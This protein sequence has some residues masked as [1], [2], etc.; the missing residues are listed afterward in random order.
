M[1]LHV[2]LRENS[3]VS[4]TDNMYS[5]F[6]DWLDEL[7][8]QQI[9]VDL[10][11]IL[12]YVCAVGL[13][14]TEVL[15]VL[16][17]RLE[18]YVRCDILGRT[19]LFYSMAYGQVDGFQSRI[20]C[21]LDQS[22]RMQM[23]AQMRQ[24][25]DINDA[26]MFHAAMLNREPHN[27]SYCLD[28]A[29]DEEHLTK[30]GD[31]VYNTLDKSDNLL[32]SSG[33]FKNEPAWKS[34]RL[35]LAR[36]RMASRFARMPVYVNMQATN[37]FEP[38]DGRKYNGISGTVGSLSLV[39]RTL[40]QYLLDSF[41]VTT[42]QTTVRNSTGDRD[43]EESDAVPSLFC[44]SSGVPTNVDIKSGAHQAAQSKPSEPETIASGLSASNDPK[45]QHEERDRFLLC[46]HIPWTNVR[47]MHSI[48]CIS[49]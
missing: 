42:R 22:R 21:R 7:E 34:T 31:T 49:C 45:S 4:H 15:D 47:F 1:I 37:S 26:T 39:Y 32:T 30:D 17:H 29:M 41:E 33:I 13:P 9:S 2:I 46:S 16:L 11:R 3:H 38:D 40:G 14:A 19:P 6:K 36:R 23:E 20:L 5:M 27:A 48:A 10:G 12:R 25:K 28:H 43:Q 44:D 35:R 24:G 8:R 18:D